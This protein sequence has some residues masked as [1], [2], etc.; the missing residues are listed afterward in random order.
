MPDPGYI[1]RYA[2]DCDSDGQGIIDKIAVGE[3]IHAPSPGNGF[4]DVALMVFDV[5]G[6]RGQCQVGPE[7][8]DPDWKCL[9]KLRGNTSFFSPEH[10]PP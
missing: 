1:V 3:R 8:R 2:A 4:A 9:E 10:T 6:G 7:H 5:S